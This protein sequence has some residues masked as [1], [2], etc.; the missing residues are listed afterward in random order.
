MDRHETFDRDQALASIARFAGQVERR[1]AGEITEDQFRPLRRANGVSL[2]LH[3]YRLRIGVPEGALDARQLRMLAHVARRYD[4]GYC[5]FTAH[6]T[7]EFHWPSLVDIP[8][9]L[10]DLA[11]VRMQAVEVSDDGL[12]DDNSVRQLSD[13]GAVTISLV[14]AGGMPGAISTGQLEAV[15]DLA[16]RHGSGEVRVG[17]EQTLFL[18]YVVPADL[19]ALHAALAAAGLATVRPV[20]TGRQPAPQPSRE[21]F[22]VDEAK[23]A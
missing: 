8:A 7:V 5:R 6:G 13:D 1:L 16:E 20:G 12:P 15:A 23:A 11:T 19:M 10:T 14:A 18:P 17:Y 3:S 2:E 22:H 4:K 21:P 9:I